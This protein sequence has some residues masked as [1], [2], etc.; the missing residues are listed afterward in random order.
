MQKNLNE[1]SIEEL[2]DLVYNKSI[3]ID[4]VLNTDHTYEEYKSTYEWMN[5]CRWKNIRRNNYWKDVKERNDK[6]FICYQLAQAAERKK[7][8]FDAGDQS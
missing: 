1:C 6:T 4:D 5:H 3:T 7:K 2:L 8:A